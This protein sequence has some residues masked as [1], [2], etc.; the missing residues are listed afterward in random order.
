M[1]WTKS[2]TVFE[3][4]SGDITQD[5]RPTPC[6]FAT[7]ST[8][9]FEKKK[10]KS[11]KMRLK[12]FP[13]HSWA[14]RQLAG[15]IQRRSTTT[16]YPK[17]HIATTTNAVS[18]TPSPPPPPHPC[19]HLPNRVQFGAIPESYVY[20]TPELPNLNECFEQLGHGSTQPHTPWQH[21]ARR[22][23]ATVVVKP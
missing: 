11:A 15:R 21:K 17:Q 13:I 23:Q 2:V 3:A 19:L 16:Q 9:R 1:P 12:W 7:G 6:G 14:A 4:V 8:V 20:R 22:H 18:C 10:A 5:S